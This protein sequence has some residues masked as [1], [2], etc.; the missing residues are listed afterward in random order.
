M[1]K[2]TEINE[3]KKNLA[4]DYDGPI[5]SVRY[6]VSLLTGGAGSEIDQDRE[7]NNLL[8]FSSVFQNSNDLSFS[9]IERPYFAP[10]PPPEIV[11]TKVGW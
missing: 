7:R 9:S 5:Y 8:Y 11:N 6:P 2:K 4:L 10:T 1:K 3:W